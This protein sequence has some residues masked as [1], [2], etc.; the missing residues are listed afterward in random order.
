MKWFTALKEAYGTYKA[1]RA[2][3]KKEE[4]EKEEAL[5]DAS[6][7]LPGSYS[8]VRHAKFA[9]TH[10]NVS[11]LL[12]EGR[13]EIYH[14]AFPYVEVA[15]FVAHTFCHQTGYDIK[16]IGCVYEPVIQPATRKGAADEIKHWAGR[17]LFNDRDFAV[18]AEWLEEYKA[19]FGPDYDFKSLLPII[20]DSERVAGVFVEHN[21]DFTPRRG[22]PEHEGKY[23]ELPEDELFD[24]WLWILN[25]TTG[26]IRCT[27]RHWV[28][29]SDSD[30][31]MYKLQLC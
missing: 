7:D 2:S 24:E 9:M 15:M 18:F 31:M 27:A 12:N 11:H 3:Q 8:F 10:G 21:L 30:A 29:E 4:N 16:K 28:F 1:V 17:L 6:G 20:N 14:Q 22:H 23:L 5:V 26:Q 19:R 25:N 13:T